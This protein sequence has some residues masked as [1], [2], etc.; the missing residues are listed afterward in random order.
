MVSIIYLTLTKCEFIYNITK[1]IL[2][3]VMG[4]WEFIKGYYSNFFKEKLMI[5]NYLKYLGFFFNEEIWRKWV[6]LLDITHICFN[7][8]CEKQKAL[9]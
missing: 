1:I 8:L 3:I 7:Y 5:P 9:L 6:K 2:N 4:Y